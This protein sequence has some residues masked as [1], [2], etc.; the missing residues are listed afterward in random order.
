M[1]RPEVDAVGCRFEFG[2]GETIR[3]L[4]ESIAVGTGAQQQIEEALRAAAVADHRED[5]TDVAIMDRGQRVVDHVLEV[6]GEGKVVDDGGVDVRTLTSD[7]RG[8]FGQDLPL[9]HTDLVWENGRGVVGDVAQ[10]EPG[11]GQVVVAALQWRSG[12]EDHVGPATGLVAIQVDRDHEVELAE[13]VVELVGI[14][15]RGHRIAG[16]DNH[17]LDLTLTGCGDL[18]GHHGGRQLAAHLRKTSNP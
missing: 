11:E 12:G 6:A 17:C 8:E 2:Q 9:V 18:L 4:S 15:R 3:N 7:D 16:N 1:E 10:R 5:L 13:G 14:G